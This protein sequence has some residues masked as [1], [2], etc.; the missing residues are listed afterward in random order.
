MFLAVFFELT[1]NIQDMFEAFVYASVVAIDS[2]DPTT[3]GHSQ[4]VADYTMFLNTEET[5]SGGL[6]GYPA[7]MGEDECREAGFEPRVIG[8]IRCG[9]T[10]PQDTERAAAEIAPRTP[11][12]P[13]SPISYRLQSALF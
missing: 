9:E 12:V 4:R 6:I 1:R 11:T 5:E 3:A 8:S 7:E 2:R 13:R 10:S